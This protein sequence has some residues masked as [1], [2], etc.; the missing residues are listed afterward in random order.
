MGKKAQ[1]FAHVTKMY[2]LPGRHDLMAAGPRPARVYLR[3]AV[4]GEVRVFAANSAEL[5]VLRRQRLP[6]PPHAR[7]WVQ[8]ARPR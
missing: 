4:T 2:P 7:A 8:I 6:E 5:V 1:R 3:H